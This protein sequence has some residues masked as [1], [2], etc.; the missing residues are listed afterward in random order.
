LTEPKFSQKQTFADT[1][2]KRIGGAYDLLGVSASTLC[3]LHCGLVPLLLTATPLLAAGFLVEEEFE[4]IM[5]GSS[6]A[7]GLF[8][9]IRGYRFHHRQWTA[10]WCFFAGVAVIVVARFILVESERLL[11]P[12]GAML[13]AVAHIQNWRL[14]KECERCKDA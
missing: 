12:A 10:F 7:I 6:V 1:S 8:A 14:C 9:L 11:L 2:G 13:I 3:A 4:W 5:I